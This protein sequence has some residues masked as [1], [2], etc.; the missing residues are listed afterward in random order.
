MKL[1]IEQRAGE[2]ADLFAMRAFAMAIPF[3]TSDQIAASSRW[4][5]AIACEKLEKFIDEARKQKSTPAESP[6]QPAPQDT[7]ES[8]KGR[9]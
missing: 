2:G 3:M 9:G 7:P 5:S 4:I 1:R 8:R 6:A